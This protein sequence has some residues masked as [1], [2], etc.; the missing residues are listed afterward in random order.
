MRHFIHLCV[1]AEEEE[2]DL[3]EA[4]A[5]VEEGVEDLALRTKFKVTTKYTLVVCPLI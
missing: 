1:Q 5:V 2:G 4:E 3:V